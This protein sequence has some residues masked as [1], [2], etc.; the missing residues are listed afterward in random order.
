[1]CQVLCYG[2]SMYYYDTESPYLVVS[3]L[4]TEDRIIQRLRAWDPTSDGP[5]L[6]APAFTSSTTL[7]IIRE[8]T[9]QGDV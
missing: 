3:I 5:G 7:R 2:L 8:P 9:F 6:L 1:M 4:Q